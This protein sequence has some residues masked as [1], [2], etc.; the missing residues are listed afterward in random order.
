M[1]L[2]LRIWNIRFDTRV[3]QVKINSYFSYSR[4]LFHHSSVVRIIIVG[5]LSDRG[6][7]QPVCLNFFVGINFRRT[8]W[9]LLLKKKIVSFLSDKVFSKVREL[10]NIRYFIKSA[11]NPPSKSHIEIPLASSPG[12]LLASPCLESCLEV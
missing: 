5:C 8:F 6:F 7:S 11:K 9:S 1:D 4:F 2:K 10:V 12:C 3:S